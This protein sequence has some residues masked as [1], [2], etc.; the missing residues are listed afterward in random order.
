MPFPKPGGG[1]GLDQLTGDVTAGPGTGAQAATLEATANVESVIAANTTVAG[2]IQGT[3][4]PGG[5]LAGTGSTYTTP[6]LIAVGTAGT[7]GDASH[8]PVVTTDAKGRVTGMVATAVP[9]GTPATTVTGP[10][11]F[12]ATA[13]VGTSTLYAR[14]DHDHGLPAAPAVPAPATTVTGPDTFGAAAVVGTGTTY[15]RVDHD[16]GLPAAP[17]DIPLSTVTAAG[18][19]IVGSGAGTVSR[20]GI[21]ANGDV[22]TVAAGALGYAAPST[23]VDLLQFFQST[24]PS[25]QN[26]FSVTYGNGAFVAVANGSTAA[27]YSTNGGVTWTASTLPSSSDWIAVTYGNGAFVAVAYNSTAAAYSTNGGVTWTASTLP[28]SA[29]WRS[30]AYGN[31]A[32]VAVAN[33]S[34]AAAYTQVVALTG[35][36][37]AAVAAPAVTSGTAFTPSVASNST[38]YFQIN[39]GS[40]GSYTLTMGPTTGAENTIASAAAVTVGN[41]VLVSLVVPRS[42]LVVLTLT[43][44]TLG[45]TTVVAM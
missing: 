4:T 41:D 32:F 26:W 38:V 35:A 24:L 14:E 36:N 3:A 39:A 12:G 9:A 11:A 29:T 20:L 37:T 17:A 10:D 8:Y 42:W 5:D 27:A 13:I 40:A 18:D 25:S 15:A 45:S 6:E 23:G 21:G 43:T 16:H 7:V 22:L 30:V 44:V 19:L 34:T 2:A 28:S 31:G 33:G 1:S